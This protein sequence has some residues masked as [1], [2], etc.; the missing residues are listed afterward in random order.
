MNWYVWWGI[1]L[2]IIVI[3]LLAAFTVKNLRYKKK[4]LMTPKRILI[5]GTFLSSFTLLCPLYAKSFPQSLGWLDWVKSALLA[6]Q[7]SIRLFAFD[8]GYWDVLDS[9]KD[10]PDS[11][12]I[13]DTVLGAFLCFFAPL[14]TVGVILSFFKNASAYVRY[15]YPFYRH[16]HVFSELNDRSL[17]LA[18]S[19]VASYRTNHK[20]WW[21]YNIAVVFT[22]V[23]EKPGSKTAE[24]AE[25]ARELG[26]IIFSKEIGSIRFTSSS[27]KRR[28][29]FYL[30]SDDEEKKILHAEGILNEYDYKTVELRIFSD[31]K[32]SELLRAAKE[33]RNMKAIRVNDIQSLIYHDLDL[34]GTRLFK[35]ARLQPDGT[36][37]ISAVIVGLGK[38]G[39][40]MLKALTWFCQLE[41][42]SI[43]INVFEQDKHAAERFR[44][45]CPE[46]MDDSL[47]GKVIPGESRYSIT[48]HDE[49]DITCDDFISELEKIRDATFVFV[50]LGGDEI[51]LSVSSRIRS[52]YARMYNMSKEREPDIETVILNSGIRKLMGEKWE[53]DPD[54]ENSKGVKNHRNQHYR[55]HM[56]GD[57]E[58]FYS[59]NTL[60]NSELEIAGLAEHMKYDGRE[61]K[62]YW[63]Y[64]YN[65]R[66]SIARVIYDRMRDKL[67]VGHDASSEHIRWNAY[68]RT[69]GF[70]SSNSSEEESRNDLAKLHHKLIIT[71]KLTEEDIKKDL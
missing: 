17:A 18:R 70:R 8:G 63:Q 43:K 13:L 69:E 53:N 57:L 71:S 27:S 12:R 50:S 6:M 59:E 28:I 15:R 48:I 11:V 22:D 29:N 58:Q 66:S 54:P 24:L 2:L 47:N 38:Y 67:N 64:E 1:S 52:E 5:F 20:F 65:Y 61:E 56:I 36:K 25:D 41:G 49:I 26:A 14:L 4:R 33:V 44:S 55:L 32:R 68:M 42:Y 30:I 19:I 31:S 10:L 39:K 62:D 34:N 46:L 16:T 23:S 21:F 9:I 35:N 3:A 7:H 40:E 45:I 51:N 60:I 37:L